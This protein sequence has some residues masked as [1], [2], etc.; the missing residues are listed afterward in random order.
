MFTVRNIVSFLPFGR[1]CMKN[2]VDGGFKPLHKNKGE[3][4]RSA[5]PKVKSGVG[6]TAWGCRLTKHSAQTM[7]TARFIIHSY[8]RAVSVERLGTTATT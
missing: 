8:V 6:P 3:R 2:I 1:Y 7:A 5:E 4:S